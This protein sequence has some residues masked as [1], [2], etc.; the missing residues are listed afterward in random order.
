M[1]ATYF[2]TPDLR[3]G[4]AGVTLRRRTG[5][6][7]AGWHLMLPVAG[8]RLEV[9][10][11]SGRSAAAVP[12][13]LVDLV[14]AQTRGQ[15]LGPVVRLRTSRAV[16]RL[17]S[18][19]GQVL[20]EVADDSVTAEPVTGPA[21]RTGTGN[22]TRPSAGVA[23]NGRPGSVCWREVEV[24]LVEGDR[25]LLARVGKRLR[26]GGARPAA[27]ASKLAR[28]LSE[29]ALPKLH[30]DGD[31]PAGTSRGSGKKLGKKVERGHGGRGPSA[32]A[33]GRA[34]PG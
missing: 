27:T 18:A 28:A 4:R 6:S 8:D 12:V 13:E 14:R 5:G 32:F 19:D 17:L 31:L 24:E 1:T 23:G 15:A 7:D 9:R 11:P 10:R 21:S 20:A 16:T 29:L 3:L 22:G 2:D 34:C 33:G 26:R 25:P 30:E